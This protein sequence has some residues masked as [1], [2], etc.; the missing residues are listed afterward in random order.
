MT[1]CVMEG[2]FVSCHISCQVDRDS[3]LDPHLSLDSP[4]EWAE[5][6]NR[7]RILVLAQGVEP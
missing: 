4:I 6:G 5:M 3:V 2:L 1:R 7:H